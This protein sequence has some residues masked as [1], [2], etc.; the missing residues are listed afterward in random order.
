MWMMRCGV[1]N[2]WMWGVDGWGGG[3]EIGWFLGTRC[4]E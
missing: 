1:E 3:E 4:E 2:G